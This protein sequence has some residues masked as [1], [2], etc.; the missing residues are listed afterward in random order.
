[1]TI[2]L[3]CV[4]AAAALPLLS[5]GVAK[6][7]G[8]FPMT[9]NAHPRE[10]QEKLDGW[11]KRAHWA[12]L[13]AFEGFPPFAA[14]VIIAQMVHAPQ[15]RVDMLAVAYIVFR[16]IYLGAYIANLS[17]LRSTIWFASVACIVGLFFAGA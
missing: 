17:T 5:T 14:G 15:A 6:A 4:L 11:P 9:A 12:Q 8:R 16:V 13:N 2:A 10:W 7:G 1:M 3:W